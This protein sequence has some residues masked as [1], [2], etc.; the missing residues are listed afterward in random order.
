MTQILDKLTTDRGINF[1]L[2]II[3]SIIPGL[4]VLFLFNYEIFKETETIK[5]L[6]IS[7]ALSIP[8]FIFTFILSFMSLTIFVDYSEK[9]TE[10]MIKYNAL[11][12]S[13]Y[14]TTL[15]WLFVAIFMCSYY[16]IKGE[17]S[18]NYYPHQIIIGYVI[19]SIALRFI[20]QMEHK[21]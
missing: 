16:F 1:I 8:F 19:L 13:V 6:L 2:I 9:K 20:Y 12:N 11:S 5:L 4:L 21:Y 15:T 10:D 14:H 3:W 17:Y 18:K 7:M